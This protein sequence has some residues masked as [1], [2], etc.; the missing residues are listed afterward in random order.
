MCA[1]AIR[2]ASPSSSNGPAAGD[3]LVEHEAGRV[4]VR[5]RRSASRRGAAR[6][7]RSAACRGSGPPVSTLLASS[8]ET[9]PKSR[10][11]VTVTPRQRAVKEDVVRLHVAVDDALVVRVI[12]RVEQIDPDVVRVRQLELPLL[13]EH[14]AQRLPAEAL[15]QVVGEPQ[16]VGRDAGGDDLDDVRVVQPRERARLVLDPLGEVFARAEPAGAASSG[17][18]ACRSSCPRRRRPCP[19]RRRR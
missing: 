19:S 13:L 15:H 8:I 17:R 3:H 12:E 14:E 5:L 4:D 11:F 18:S 9:M 1:A 10:S 7:R 2:C 6:A 16:V